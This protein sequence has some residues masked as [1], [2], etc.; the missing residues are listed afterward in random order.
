MEDM[1]EIGKKNITT[2]FHE[3]TTFPI[4]QKILMITLM[5]MAFLGST[6]YWMDD[7]QQVYEISWLV[8]SSVWYVTILFAIM[9]VSKKTRLGYMIAGIFSWVTMSFWLFDNFYVVFDMSLIAQEPSLSMTIRNFLGLALAGLAIF[10][11]HNLFHK[12]RKNQNN[13]KKI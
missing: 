2:E 5:T 13:S 11:S 10:S 1:K 7:R 9:F 3:R 6:Y 8:A 12:I 4:N